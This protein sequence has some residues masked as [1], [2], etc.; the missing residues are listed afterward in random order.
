MYKTRQSELLHF[1]SLLQASIHEKES[2][3]ARVSSILEKMRNASTSTQ[4]EPLSITSQ[5]DVIIEKKK[6]V[7]RIEQKLTD[8]LIS[9]V[10]ELEYIVDEASQG[11][12]QMED[13]IERFL[14]PDIS[15]DVQ[16]EWSEIEAME[17]ALG[18]AVEDMI[19]Y[20]EKI[21]VVKNRIDEVL[22]NKNILLGPQ[23]N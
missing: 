23:S 22:A 6:T 18:I 7:K 12:M 2:E 21:G 8:D 17:E 19:T 1:I 11:L 10:N 20:E 13:S 3:V 15:V 16:Y 4:N 14:R 9:C 5:L